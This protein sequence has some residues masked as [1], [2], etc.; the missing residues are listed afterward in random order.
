MFTH[1]L[2]RGSAEHTSQD[3]VEACSYNAAQVAPAHVAVQ[4]HH[5]L[6]CIWFILLL[7]VALYQVIVLCDA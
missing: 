4:Q 5:W 6:Y 1:Q 7:V 3:P 2:R